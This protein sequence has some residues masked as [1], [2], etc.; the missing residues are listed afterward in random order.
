[1]DMARS[2]RWSA[3]AVSAFSLVALAGTALGSASFTQLGFL[4]P[5]V[6]N[7]EAWGILNDGSMVMG[8]SICS[9]DPITGAANGS[10]GWYWTPATGMVSIADP[11][12]GDIG[13]IVYG[14][15]LDGSM[16]VGSGINS[17]GWEA[18]SYAPATSTYTMLGGTVLSPFLGST[19]AAA[20]HAGNVIVGTAEAVPFGAEATVWTN[21]ALQGL[22]WLAVPGFLSEAR[23]TDSTG[24]VVVGYTDSDAEGYVPFVWA[25]EGPNAGRGLISLGGFPGP[26]L[27][28][29]DAH[30]ISDDATTIVGYSN[31]LRG[32]EAYRWTID[33]DGNGVMRSIGALDRPAGPEALWL[34]YANSTNTDGTIVVGRSAGMSGLMEPIIWEPVRGFRSLR[35]ALRAQGVDVDAIGFDMRNATAVAAVGDEI[36]VVGYGATLASP[37]EAYLAVLDRMCLADYNQD[38]MLNLDD[39]GDFISDFYLEV[40]IPGGEQPAAPTYTDLPAGYSGECPFAPDAASPYWVTAYRKWGYR[41]GFSADGSNSCPIDPSASFPNLDNLGDYI[42]QYYNDAA[43]CTY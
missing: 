23:S 21:G 9:L 43:S 30:D 41:V 13:G 6:R 18:F 42:T 17:N 38:G 3:G 20:N 33:D 34:S 27:V 19:A 11:P 8:T 22:G 25:S 7:S 31:S 39:L 40:P 37:S 1:M 35:G 12:L 32:T 36:K 16:L 5:T 24:F 28:S 2:A 4:N 26:G 10:C 15:N 29:A 14:H